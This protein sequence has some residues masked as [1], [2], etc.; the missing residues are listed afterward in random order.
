MKGI[1]RSAVFAMIGLWAM[2]A[3]GQ[4]PAMFNYQGALRQA[5]GQPLGNHEA[6]IRLTILDGSDRG[7]PI[8]SETRKVGTNKLGLYQLA[9]GGSP[10]AATL[11]NL[12][13]IDWGGGPKYLKV[14]A[15]ANGGSNFTDAG[16]A[17]LLSVPYALFAAN[18]R[19][20]EKGEKGERG[21]PGEVGPK[22][23][24]GDP[25]SQGP[26][27]ER[28]ERGERG[29]KGEPGPAGA[30]GTLMGPWFAS[31]N[32]LP[33]QKNE[34]HIYQSGHVGIMTA[35]PLAPLDVRGAVRF[36]HPA[37]NRPIGANSAAFGYENTASG[38]NAAS[39]GLAN[40]SSGA[41]ST[42][43]G[44]T[45]TASGSR[46]T[47]FGTMS[48][49]SGDYSTSFGSTNKVSGWMSM[50][51]GGNLKV[52][53]NFQLVAG[54]NNAM[55][56]P[57]ETLFQL[58]NGNPHNPS[59]LSNAMTVT[60]YGYTGMGTSTAT[61]NSTLQIF[62]SLSLPIRTII[63]GEPDAN[64]YTLLVRGMIS[65]PQAS[66]QNRGRIYQLVNDTADQQLVRGIIRI[67]GKEEPGLALDIQDGH[68]SALVQ[69]DGKSWIVL[70]QY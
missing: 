45:N 53:G 41:Y 1:L 48:E 58:G 23:E 63:D 21:M 31:E 25:G 12:Q 54:T 69:S 34:Q 32:G 57:Q 62:G 38:D 66:A 35:V 50:A 43:F 55:T 47:V 26:V 20:G 22:G 13:H 49:V 59:E 16:T 61:P 24:Q 65:L 10:A 19:P 7:N 18:S 29:E 67:N 39:F 5:N 70:N 11:G 9:I 36:G 46:A 4:A 52:P 68:R 3:S 28:G 6:T 15:D 56:D 27:G 14:E 17:Q 51:I 8:Y 40:I 64:D 33:A 30:E 37:L 42:T 2:M 60:R 44:T